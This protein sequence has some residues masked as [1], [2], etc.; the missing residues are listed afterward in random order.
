MK[1]TDARRLTHD[2]L[3]EL[4]RRGVTAVQ[5]GESP[6]DVV[7]VLGISRATIYGWLSRYRQ[8]GWG[9]LDAKKRG[10]RV[11]VKYFSHPCGK[12][13]SQGH[14][15]DISQPR[16]KQISHPSSE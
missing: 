16:G 9:Q 13:I 6:E 2:Q 3:T 11:N 1:N 12:D 14:G 4:R 7:R 8:G 5:E 15:K 10:G